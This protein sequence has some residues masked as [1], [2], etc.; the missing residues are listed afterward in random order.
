[1][2]LGYLLL[3]I[4]D[5]CFIILEF[6]YLN[7]HP[8]AN[9]ISNFS[10]HSK[11][12]RASRV[13]IP[14]AYL[15]IFKYPRTYNNRYRYSWYLCT[16]NGSVYIRLHS[17]FS[18]L[19]ES[20]YS[21]TTSKQAFT[22]Q[23]IWCYSKNIDIRPCRNISRVVVP[24]GGFFRVYLRATK[25]TRAPTMRYSLHSIIIGSVWKEEGSH[26]DPL[27]LIRGRK[28]V[29]Q[30]FIDGGRESFHSRPLLVMVWT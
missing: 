11:T 14:S 17:F 1:M 5:F 2:T 8:W 10:V 4:V 27:A 24:L 28:R 6:E 13:L 26:C 3:L 30:S 23:R 21:S 15:F 25:Y 20:S 29:W 19:V 12:P 9:Q 18:L 22:Y 7:R 16:I